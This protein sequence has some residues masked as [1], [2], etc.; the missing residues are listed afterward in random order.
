MQI[1]LVSHYGEKSDGLASYIRNCQSEISISL[2]SAF[3][4][5]NLHQVHGTI[6]GMEGCINIG[7]I[8]NMNF[9]EYRQEI[10]HMNPSKILEFLR[11]PSVPE[12]DVQI[13]GYIENENYGFLSQGQHP[14]LRSFSIQGENV[15]AMG[16]PTDLSSILD[17]FRRSFNR[18]NILH[19][20]HKNES[21]IDNDFFFVLGQV[22]RDVLT[23]EEIFDVEI[24]MRQFMASHDPIIL[25]VNV[26]SLRLVSYFDAKLPLD[27]SKVHDI[28]NND[29]TPE[30][31]ARCY[32]D[33]NN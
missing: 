3:T 16:W 28:H 24:K 4:S 6:I 33:C 9:N 30:D 12:F 25:R 14:Y 19:K 8:E 15:V 26:C 22:N 20:Y 7:Q 10:R 18:L 21:T 23:N 31:F 32:Y 13:G 29:F 1:T 2:S 27:T 11:S 5:Y 17:D